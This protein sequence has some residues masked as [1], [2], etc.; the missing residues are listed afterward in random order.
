VSGTS[1]NHPKNTRKYT[2]FAVRLLPR[3][4]FSHPSKQWLLHVVPLVILVSSLMLQ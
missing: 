1:R 2:R 3:L 4:A